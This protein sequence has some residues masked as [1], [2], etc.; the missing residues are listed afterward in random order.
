MS[1]PTILSIQVGLPAEHGPDHI[2]HK[3]WQS[4]IFKESVSGRIWLDTFN[5]AGD[6]QEDLDN[7]GGQFR[8]VLAYGADHYPI[9]KAEL[10]LAD[11]PY[12]SFGEN[13]TV[14]ELTEDIVCL[15]DVYEIGEVR[16]QVSQPRAPCWKLAR[17]NGIKDLAA[18]VE[19]KGWGGWYHQVLQT[20][21]VEPGDSYQLLE[22]PYPQFSIA[23]LNDLI[24]EREENPAVCAELAEIEA[25]SPGWR[26]MY[27]QKSATT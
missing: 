4:G 16:L 18:R 24:A 11:F 2:S 5:L 20:G 7:H 12:G 8:A 22:H 15:G 3:S 13:F 10:S 14:S 27:A 21:F 17:R 9:W 19:A 25:L 1:I 26:E 23:R 6:G